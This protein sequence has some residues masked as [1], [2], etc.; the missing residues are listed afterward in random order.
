MDIKSFIIGFLLAACFFLLTGFGGSDGRYQ[1][2][3]APGMVWILDTETGIAK[4]SKLNNS[5]KMLK[6]V[7]D[8]SKGRYE[9][10]R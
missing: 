8:Y 4:T 7:F 3:A 10:T 9:R 6:W 1:I 2:A 5:G